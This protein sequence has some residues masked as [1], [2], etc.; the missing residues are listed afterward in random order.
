MDLAAKLKKLRKAKGLSQTDVAV[1]IG[2]D[3]SAVSLW[4]KGKT[5]SGPA[6]ILLDRFIDEKQREP[7]PKQEH[8]A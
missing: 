6:R 8:A 5:P 4:E 7:A 2:V 3:Q 1:A